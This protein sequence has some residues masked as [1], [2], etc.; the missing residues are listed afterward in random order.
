MNTQITNIIDFCN[1]H[2][3]AWFPLNLEIVKTNKIQWGEPKHDKVFMPIQHISYG[4][5]GKARFTD[6]KTLT[7]D[8]IK[9]RQA[10]LHNN[11]YTFNYIA[12]DTARVYHIDFDLPM[13]E[14][15]EANRGKYEL[16]LNMTP[17]FNSSTKTYGRHAL[18]TTDTT[19]QG[20]KQLY[21]RDDGMKGDVELLAG[22]WSYAP[23]DAVMHNADDDILHMD[24]NTFATYYK[25]PEPRREAPASENMDINDLAL[26]PDEA[27]KLFQC[28]SKTRALA[29]NEWINVFLATR[30]STTANAV[31]IADAFAKWS[32]IAQYDTDMEESDNKYKFLDAIPSTQQGCLT[33]KSLHYWAIQDNKE[34]HT[35]LFPREPSRFLAK[36]IA[37]YMATTPVIHFDD[38]QNLVTHFEHVSKGHICI[39]ST[40]ELCVYMNHEW[41]SG[42]R[43]K[44]L[45]RYAISEVFNQFI[46]HA[47]DHNNE[48]T[49]TIHIDELE[50]NKKERNALINHKKKICSDNF[51]R[52]CTSIFNASLSKSKRIMFDTADEYDYHIQFKNGVF[53]IKTKQLRPRT[54]NDHVTRILDWDYN[55]N[56]ST[57]I[58]EYVSDVF[59]KIHPNETERAFALS[60]LHYALTGNTTNQIFKINWGA[61]AANGKSTEL[62]I[63]A[64]CFP[65]Y[66]LK[67]N[68]EVLN[69]GF[70]KRHKALAR[71]IN[72]PIRLLYLEE[73][74][75]RR[76]DSEFLKDIVDGKAF[77]IEQMYDTDTSIKCKAKGCA[78]TNHEP[79]VDNDEGLKRRMRVQ[80]YRSRFLDNVEDDYAECV[81]SRDLDVYDRFS[82]DE[83]KN[84]YFQ[85]LLQ[86]ST[87]QVPTSAKALFEEIAEENDECVGKFDCI[88][89]TKS[90]QD[91]LTRHECN[92]AFGETAFKE[93]KAY[94]AKKGIEYRSQ[95][96]AKINGKC[97]KG[98]FF[99][100]KIVTEQ[101]DDPEYGNTDDERFEQE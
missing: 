23:I 98:A 36:E 84:A 90:E 30:N 42:K 96:V 38:Q 95:H 62:G 66:S 78:A 91:K 17:S 40:E 1:K 64:K 94:L 50:N 74:N 101:A 58:S 14:I 8:K 11:A 10:L 47:L 39:N 56:V 33:K 68:G 3:I 31:E 85:Y 71:M 76:L 16:L 55:P 45:I 72:E 69:V 88:K 15:D 20:R 87:L 52:A 92:M 86:F 53:D 65:I 59:R 28:L 22:E 19:V 75:P 6:F 48:K 81:F 99:G 93:L 80:K 29:Y 79:N 12:M 89:I 43:A 9:Q 60:Y 73:L 35:T 77:S 25:A 61:T 41:M 4:A 82:N 5:D 70:A 46:N 32:R 44:E 49:K 21:T 2:S 67:I 7:H 100:I 83:Y 51:I 18:I 54:Q 13:N 24:T 97:H 37:K 26:T 63:H 57:N 27:T 34:L